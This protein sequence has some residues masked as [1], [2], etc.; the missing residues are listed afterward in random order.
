MSWREVD[1]RQFYIVVAR[2]FSGGIG[3][4]SLL[5]S[6]LLAGNI[7]FEL[8]IALECIEILI[9]LTQAQAGEMVTVS[10]PRLSEWHTGYGIFLGRTRHKD[11]TCFRFCHLLYSY[12]RPDSC[13][14]TSRSQSAADNGTFIRPGLSGVFWPGCCSLTVC[15]PRIGPADGRP[16]LGAFC[17]V[18]LMILTARVFLWPRTGGYPLLDARIPTSLNAF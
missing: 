16:F 3:T 17:R 7:L 9:L 1:Q 11:H 10:W 5:T 6:W 2:A 15:S 18:R 12:I 13:F 14:S 8:A 4:R